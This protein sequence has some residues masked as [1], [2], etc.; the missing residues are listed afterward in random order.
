MDL[1]KPLYKSHRRIAPENLE[2]FD[3][4]KSITEFGG[5]HLS[6]TD[7]GWACEELPGVKILVGKLSIADQKRM[8]RESLV[9][10]LTNPEHLTN[11]DAHHK[12]E[13]PIK[14][15]T[16]SPSE[17]AANKLVRDKLRWVT[18]GGQY[19]WTTKEYP[20]FEPGSAGCPLFPASK[21]ADVAASL[22]MRPEAAIVNYYAEGDILSP[23]QD[24]AEL[25]RENLVSISLGCTCIFYI[26]L[27]RYGHEPLPVLLRSGD[28]LVM[29]GDARFAFHGVGRVFAHTTPEPL[30]EGE[31]TDAS[32]RDWM[33]D[34]RV[35]INVRQ[36]RA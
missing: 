29:G 19:N 11:L 36:M 17:I 4:H 16:E 5:Y 35:N 20:S 21:T 28:I 10:F 15:F 13:R 24:V 12:I 6:N 14:M 3:P 1:F 26:G 27:E 9:D 18:L 8:L 34:H 7:D 30:L 33:R 23:H 31:D 2:V 32:F 22:G 25:S